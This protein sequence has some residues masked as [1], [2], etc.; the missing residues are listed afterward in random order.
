MSPYEEGKKAQPESSNPYKNLSGG[1]REDR[2]YAEVLR[3]RWDAGNKKL[4]DPYPEG[5]AG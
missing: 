2:M 5:W 1:D 3:R 4:P